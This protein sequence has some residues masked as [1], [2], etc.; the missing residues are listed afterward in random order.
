[1]YFCTGK[2]GVTLRVPDG[3]LRMSAHGGPADL[4][5]FSCIEKNAPRVLRFQ[6]VCFPPFSL[7]KADGT[8]LAHAG[9]RCFAVRASGQGFRVSALPLSGPVRAGRQHDRFTNRQPEP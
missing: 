1:M 6:D 8:G 7:E 2:K 5:L 3:A 9:R 4:R